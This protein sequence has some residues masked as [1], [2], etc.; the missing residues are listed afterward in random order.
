MDNFHYALTSEQ[1]QFYKNEGYLIIRG[2]FSSPE[3]QELQQ[4]AQEVHDLP[5]IG[6]VPYMPYEVNL[7]KLVMGNKHSNLTDPGNQLGRKES[8]LSHGELRQ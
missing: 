5:R 6:D 7:Q 4:W 1:L 8:S 2:F 3:S